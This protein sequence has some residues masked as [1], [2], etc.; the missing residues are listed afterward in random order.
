MFKTVAGDEY[1]KF[2]PETI[3]LFRRR[4]AS[5][6]TTL[7]L[8]QIPRRARHHL[9]IFVDKT[10]NPQIAAWEKDHNNFWWKFLLSF[11]AFSKHNDDDL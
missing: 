5:A 3:D 6:Q 1:S 4:E 10:K 8:M 11:G 2:D 9:P 7:E